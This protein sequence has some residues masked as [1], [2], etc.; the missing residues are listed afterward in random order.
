MSRY[1]LLAI[2]ALVAAPAIAQVAAPAVPVPAAITADGV[3]PIPAALADRTRPYLEAR[4]A[5]VVDWNPRDRSLLIAT[6]FANVAQL[7]TVAAPL[8][9]RRQITFEADRVSSAR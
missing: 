4:S 7:H 8:A 1:T 3:P 5:A 6:R 9:M 2:P